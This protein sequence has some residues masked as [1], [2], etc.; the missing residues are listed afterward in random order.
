[1]KRILPP[2]LLFFSLVAVHA[3]GDGNEPARHLPPPVVQQRGSLHNSRIRFEREKKGRVAFLGGSITEMTGWRDLVCEELRKRFPDTEFDFINAGIAST[4]ST[5]GAFRFKRDVLCNGPVDLLFEE[6]AVND[7]TNGFGDRE[8]I[9]GM[10]GIVR[11]ARL[12]NP[13]TDV[14]MLYFVCDEMLQSL[15]EG[16]MPQVILNHEKVAEYYRIPSINLALEVWQRIRDGEFDWDTFGGTHPAP[17]GH[18]VYAAAV[19]RLFDRMWDTASSGRPDKIMPHLLPET[20]LEVFGYFGGRLVDVRMAKPGKGWKY[21]VRWQPDIRAET[22]RGFVDVPALEAL[23]A[24]AQLRFSFT[25][26]AVGIF[27]VAGPD[28]GV[29]EYSV[30]GKPFRRKDLFTLWSAELYIPWVTLLESELDEGKHVLVIRTAEVHNPASKGT[31][32]RIFYF[33][34]NEP[35]D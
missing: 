7:A 4:G 3:A 32:C 31:A 11:Q 24:G 18:K 27:H 34:V 5:P 2:L 19:S 23:K 30:D 29:I 8:Q 1:M 14:V 33:T 25:G 12:A 28:A 17:Y 35:D 16:N 6:A 21:I 26:N 22:R 9:R 20:P 10:E 13:N 15:N